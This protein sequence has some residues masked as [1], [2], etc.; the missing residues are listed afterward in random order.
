MFD[1]DYG[2]C[3]RGVPPS[4][5]WAPGLLGN[6]IAWGSAGSAYTRSPWDSPSTITISIDYAIHL[7]HRALGETEGDTGR[8]H[9]RAALQA[10]V[11][12]VTLG[13]HHRGAAAF[14]LVAASSFTSVRQL[15]A[16]AASWRTLV[17]SDV[18]TS[19]NAATAV[20][21]PSVTGPT[22]ARSAAAHARP[23]VALGLAE[24]PVEQVD[25]VVDAD[26]GDGRGEAQG[27]RVH[28]QPGEPH[29]AR[30]DR[31][32]EQAGHERERQEPQAPEEEE[33]HAGHEHR[34]RDR[35][36]LEVRDE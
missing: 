34:D 5:A 28:A 1:R 26:A 18:A 33:E 27:E 17:N 10:V 30:G 36:P 13:V 24:R 8:P 21:H 3:R 23:G 29:G 19:R 14:L 9:G 15:A 12:P 22:T 35:A 25:R 32:A 31:V 16:N 11:G 2:A 4:G 6:A 20:A 7:Y